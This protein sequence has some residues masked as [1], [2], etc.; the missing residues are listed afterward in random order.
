MNIQ[1]ILFYRK[2]IEIREEKKDN[3]KVLIFIIL[4]HFTECFKFLIYIE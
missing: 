1:N 3:K 4:Y 2:K